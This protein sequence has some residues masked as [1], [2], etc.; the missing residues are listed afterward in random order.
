MLVGSV[1][2]QVLLDNRRGRRERGLVVLQ[3]DGESLDV[4]EGHLVPIREVGVALA[5]VV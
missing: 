5:E 1:G 2:V 3:E 4:V